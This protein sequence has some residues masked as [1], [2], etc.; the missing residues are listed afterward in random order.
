[1]A[2]ETTGSVIR[3]AMVTFAAVTE[4]GGKITNDK[5]WFLPLKAKFNAFVVRQGGP[6]LSM[7]SDT[8]GALRLSRLINNK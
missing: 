6:L 1:M 7:D 8:S 3:A 5:I 2:D 4:S